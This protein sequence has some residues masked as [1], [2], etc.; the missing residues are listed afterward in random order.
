MEKSLQR[1]QINLSLAHFL[2]LLAN[3]NKSLFKGQRGVKKWFMVCI[4]FPKTIQ[5]DETMERFFGM[6]SY[7]RDFKQLTNIHESICKQY[8][9]V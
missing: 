8:Y 9:S 3:I 4:F 7:L 2:C 1:T 6:H 5:L